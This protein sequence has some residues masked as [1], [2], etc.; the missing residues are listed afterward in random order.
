MLLLSSTILF[1]VIFAQPSVA[2]YLFQSKYPRVEPVIEGC[3]AKYPNEKTMCGQM[4]TC[5]LDGVSSDYPARWSAG[6]SILAFIP[7]IVGLMSNS[8]DEVTAIAE[9][10]KFLAIAVSLSSVTTFSTRLGDKVTSLKLGYQD[11]APEYL[12]A[13]QDSIIESIQN[14]RQKHSRGWRNTRL[15][16]ALIGTAMIGISTL[17]WYELCLVTRY[18][19]VTFACPVKVNVIL[20][21]LLGQFLPLLSILSRRYSYEYRKIHIKRLNGRA[22]RTLT[23]PMIDSP[24]VEDEIGNVTIVLR[25]LRSTRLRRALQLVIAV[26]S[27]AFYTFGTVVLASI[28]LFE[29]ADALRVVVVVCINAGIGRV[30]GY[31]AISLRKGKKAILFDVPAAHIGKI[32]EMINENF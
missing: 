9:E 2:Y 4:L 18:G 25:C 10:S 22:R 28:T 3:R 8:V 29:A 30:V 24:E 17:I 16:D 12:Q 27:F 23:E 20:W 15:Q 19:I 32:S 7:T 11:M 26:F 21:A 31:W 6:A 14:N 5:I 1:L 13:A